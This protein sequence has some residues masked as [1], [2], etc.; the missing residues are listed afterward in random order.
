MVV[1]SDAGSGPHV[2]HELRREVGAAGPFPGR[3]DPAADV[4]RSLVPAAAA[5]RPLLDWL[6]GR[7]GYFDARG[8]ARE[9]AAGRITRNGAPAAPEARLDAG[10]E[11][12]FRPAAPHAADTAPPAILYADG[13]LVV[14]DKPAHQVVQAASAFAV[15]LLPAVAAAL[16][17]AAGADR[18]EPVHR[19]DRETSGVLVL[20][21][22]G[23]AAAA[24]RRQ[25]DAG[26]VH[27]QYVAVVHGRVAAAASR[28]VGAIGRAPGSAVRARRAVVPAGTPGARHA[29]TD[30]VVEQRLA[31][32]AVLRITPRTGRTHQIRVH[33]EHAGHAIVG[34]KLYGQ[35]D[36]RYLAY[37]QH[38]RSGG[39]PAWPGQAAAPRLLLHAHRLWCRH[40]RGTPLHV[41]APVP[42][43]LQV[44]VAACAGPG[45]GT[46][47]SLPGTPD[48]GDGPG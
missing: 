11:I 47:G 8:W 17:P 4:L 13:D 1:G 37:V 21:R 23:A 9:L 16:A 14:V 10:D 25:F 19:L 7:F 18:L 45:D 46:A 2:Y 30:L 41:E 43:A 38:L 35:A 33:L 48:P 15:S 20:A 36:G 3:Y 27:K 32:H 40:P 28:I 31:A 34:D 22:H 42:A 12:V 29:E 44:F 5:G 26:E 24:L 6:A 39:D